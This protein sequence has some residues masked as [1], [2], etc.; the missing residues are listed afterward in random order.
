MLSD[1]A[2]AFI[3]VGLITIVG[4]LVKYLCDG[5]QPA[6]KPENTDDD[7][8]NS[9]DD[10]ESE[11]PPEPSPEP[12]KEEKAVPFTRPQSDFSAD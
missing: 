10:S 8:E 11:P 12:K 5:D 4:F 2:L 7:S 3:L 1:Q 9:D 6:E